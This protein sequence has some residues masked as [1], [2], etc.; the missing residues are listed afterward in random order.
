M[1]K[2]YNVWL[3]VGIIAVLVL[4][5]VAS[6]WF[7]LGKTNE[8]KKTFKVV[9]VHADG[10]EKTFEYTSEEELLGTVLQ[11]EGLITGE[12]GPYGL[13]IKAVDGET[14]DYDKDGAY[15]EVFVND[16]SSNH[17][18]DQIPIEDGATYKLVYTKG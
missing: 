4:A 18:I 15:W 6:T 9:V 1:F 16:N 7:F 5:I 2:K 10:S 3:I 8:G 17:G 12:Q 13:Y 11:A 14:A